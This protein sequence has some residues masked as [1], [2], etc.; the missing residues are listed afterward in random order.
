MRSSQ[1]HQ[2]AFRKRF[3]HQRPG[4]VIAS[5]AGVAF[6]KN[7]VLIVFGIVWALVWGLVL[8]AVTNDTSIFGI[9]DMGVLQAVCFLILCLGVVPFGIG[10]VRIGR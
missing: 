2:R 9:A 8:V 7:I 6:F 10:I 3:R 4:W 5:S 1:Y